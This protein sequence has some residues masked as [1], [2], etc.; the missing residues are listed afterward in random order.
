MIL[1]RRLEAERRQTLSGLMSQCTIPDACTNS[2]PV[3]S[4]VAKV[5]IVEGLKKAPLSSEACTY[6]SA[7]G[8]RKQKVRA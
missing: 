4:C 6:L 3:S 8:V 2:M 1:M 7:R 5:A